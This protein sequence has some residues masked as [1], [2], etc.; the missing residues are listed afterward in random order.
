MES[1]PLETLRRGTDRSDPPG[2]L[3]R[4]LKAEASEPSEPNTARMR[5]IP[6]VGHCHLPEFR[7]STQPTMQETRRGAP[8]DPSNTRLSL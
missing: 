1:G 3:P 7:Y 5:S 8:D 4:S 6:L 2:E